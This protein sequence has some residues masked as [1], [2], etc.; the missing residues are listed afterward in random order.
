MSRVLITVR[1]VVALALVST[2]SIQAASNEEPFGVMAEE[3]WKGLTERSAGTAPLRVAIWPFDEET[4]PVSPELGREY[5][6]RLLARLLE[7]VRRRPDQPRVRFVER[8][9]LG[10]IIEEVRET[11]VFD[12]VGNPVAA[13][14]DSARVDVLIIG[15][16]RAVSASS[17]DLVVVYR[18]VRVAN[19]E[20]IAVTTGRRLVGAIKSG[21]PGIAL[22]QAIGRAVDV[23][24]EAA[25]DMTELRLGGISYQ[26]TGVQTSVGPYIEE[27]VGIAL[28][29][30]Y[31]NVLSERGLIVKRAELTQGDIARLQKSDSGKSGAPR[32]KLLRGTIWDFGP[33]PE[34]R[35]VLRTGGATSCAAIRCRRA[36]VLP[37]KG[38]LVPWKTI[39]RVPL[40]LNYQ[41]G[42]GEHHVT[43]SVNPCTY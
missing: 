27:Q 12:D 16:L 4:S 17:T 2:G 40:P 37:P 15:R 10:I 20:D 8:E 30:A 5:N 24:R 19:G 9:E 34:L 38:T 43:K 23:L 28:Q 26:A 41:A 25:P 31:R 42:V 11:T 1:V 14:L 29:R 39:C 36:Y 3:L 33:S 35:L 32:V 7:R 21:R 22:E 13:L 18:A 6:G